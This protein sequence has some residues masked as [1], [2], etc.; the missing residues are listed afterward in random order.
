ML[1]R[2]IMFTIIWLIFTKFRVDSLI[3]GMPA[4]IL[5]SIVS[6]RLSNNNTHNISVA[7]VTS[8]CIFFIMESLKGGV[9]IA[10]RVYARNLEI[11][12]FYIEYESN[13]KSETQRLLFSCCV[14]LLPGTLT[15]SLNGNSMLIHSL[16]ESQDTIENIKICENKIRHM[17][18]QA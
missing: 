7:G 2:L 11:N 1:A 12:P 15:A 3:V 16:I 6:Y 14:S 9:D 4:I 13:L 10:K 17:L 18:Y 8:F 5:S